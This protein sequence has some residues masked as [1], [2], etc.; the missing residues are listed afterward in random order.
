MA[1]YGDKQTQQLK[2]Q[3]EQQMQRLLKQLQDCED[4]KDD[5]DVEEYT[6]T[7]NVCKETPCLFFILIFFINN[8]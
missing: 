1:S 5:L 8:Y 3:I 6:E 7:K 2:Q 4:C